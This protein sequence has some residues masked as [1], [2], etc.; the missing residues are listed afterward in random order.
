MCGQLGSLYCASKFAL[1]GFSELLAKEV[2]PFGLF[3]TIVELG[4]FRT[5]FLTPD[6][7]RF[8]HSPIADYDDRRVV[9]QEG[10]EQRNGRQ[11]GDPPKLAQA[12]MR[13]AKEP[14]PLEDCMPRSNESARWGTALIT[15]SKDFVRR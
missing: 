3:E 15:R 8:A 6:P 13:L 1:E 7:L 14:T 5:D 12:L 10:I 9:L 11:P 2:S 4:P